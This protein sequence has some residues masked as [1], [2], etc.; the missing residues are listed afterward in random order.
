MSTSLRFLVVEDVEILRRA[1]LHALGTLGR[2]EGVGTAMDAR[3]TLLAHKFDSMVVDVGLPDGTGLDLVSF[4]MQRWPAICVL[5]L[6]GSAEH[7]VI[8]RCHELGVRYLLKPFDT[9][10]L[11]VHAQETRARREALK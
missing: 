3:S 6:T 7:S 11:K 10:Q 1:L 5:V 9:V 8:A 4:A 2:V